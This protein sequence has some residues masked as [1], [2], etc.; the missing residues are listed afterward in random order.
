MNLVIDLDI[1]GV[2]EISGDM[3]FLEVSRLVSKVI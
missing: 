1:K 2:E 3:T